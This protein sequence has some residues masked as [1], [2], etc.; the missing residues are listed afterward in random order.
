ML[1]LATP[2]AA[3][4]SADLSLHKTVDKPVVCIGQLV[5]YTVTLTN[6]GP[7]V[8]RAIRFGDAIPDPLNFV[9]CECTNSVLDGGASCAL[10]SLAVGASAIAT[11]VTT[12][13][14][15]PAPSEHVVENT[16]F[17]GECATPDPNLTNNTSSVTIRISHLPAASGMD[18]AARLT[19]SA[20]AQSRGA[21]VQLSFEL[22]EFSPSVDLAVFDV[23]GRR[24]AN[25]AHGPMAAG[26]HVVT[27]SFDADASRVSRGIYFAR[28]QTSAA[29]ATVIVPRLR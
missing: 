15:N 29:T 4:D 23:R 6:H 20:A 27:W 14:T 2:A 9:S 25:L 19:L 21:G 28:L 7:S 17:I 18:A 24:I 12:P 8:A 3:A 11:I 13:I 5:T 1:A 22:P 26:A 10:D 16:A